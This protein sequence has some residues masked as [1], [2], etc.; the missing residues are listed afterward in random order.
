MKNIFIQLKAKTK[1]KQDP[2]L[3]ILE[4]TEE[5]RKTLPTYIE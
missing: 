3:K 5:E 1:L 2:L 4:L